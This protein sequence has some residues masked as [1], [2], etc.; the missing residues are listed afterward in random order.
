MKIKSVSPND[1]DFL[2]LCEKLNTHLEA[3]AKE[4]GFKTMIL[5]TWE[6]LDGAVKLYEKLG[7]ARCNGEIIHEID[8]W[9]VYFTKTIL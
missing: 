7:Y 5:D 4:Q 6:Q 2:N 3:K 8:K 1:K 9:C